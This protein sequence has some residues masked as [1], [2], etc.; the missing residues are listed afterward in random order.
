MAKPF[1]IEKELFI[2]E[3][4]CYFKLVDM[5]KINSIGQNNIVRYLGNFLDFNNNVVMCFVIEETKKCYC[6]FA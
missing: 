1:S 5:V 2:E 4:G 6:I 3:H